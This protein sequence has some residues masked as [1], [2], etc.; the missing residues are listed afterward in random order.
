MS[1]IH[2]WEGA[3]NAPGF[4]AALLG[5][6]RA[7]GQIT[8]KGRLPKDEDELRY[9]AAEAIEAG[10]T[11]FSLEDAA[12][13]R[14]STDV[15]VFAGLYWMCDYGGISGPF[16][17]LEEAVDSVLTMAVDQDAVGFYT[18][19]SSSLPDGFLSPRCRKLVKLGKD[20]TIN[21]TVYVRTKAG[22]VPKD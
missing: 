19:V 5:Y 21:G 15:R 14:G 2:D 7:K 10:D 9:L 13:E 1:D 8:P 16:D 20:F 12:G 17:N 4:R 6:C 3:I 11:E 22:L 18:Q